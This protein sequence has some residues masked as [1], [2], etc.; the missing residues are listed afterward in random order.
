MAE[1]MW[2][3]AEAPINQWAV[4]SIYGIFWRWVSIHI[5][6]DLHGFWFLGCNVLPFV[7]IDIEISTV[8]GAE[9][10]KSLKPNK[11]AEMETD[12]IKDNDREKKIKDL[13]LRIPCALAERLGENL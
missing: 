11:R 10:L 6:H 3:Q 12:D 9:T 13:H 5:H 8:P 2:F 4:R 1:G 7:I